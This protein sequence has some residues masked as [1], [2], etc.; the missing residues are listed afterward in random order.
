MNNPS[1]LDLGAR[2]SMPQPPALS[3]KSMLDHLGTFQADLKVVG[4]EGATE[5]PFAV[6][7]VLPGKTNPV[8]LGD[9]VVSGLR[10]SVR[11]VIDACVLVA[12]TVRRFEGDP[13]SLYEFLDV[14]AGGNVIPRKQARLGSKSSKLSKLRKI[15]DYAELLGRNEIIKHLEPGYTVNYHVTLLYDALPGDEDARVKRLVQILEAEGGLSREFLIEQ[16]RLA[17]QAARLQADPEADLW[18]ADTV[19]A[20][21][22]DFDLILLTPTRRD[23]Q[24]LGEDYAGEVP[25]CLRVHER[26]AVKAIAMSLPRL[27]IFR[28][29]EVGLLPSCGFENI[30]HVFLVREPVDA[31]VTGAQVIV[32]AERGVGGDHIPDFQWLPDGESLDD[33]YLA[34]RLVPDAKNKLH[35]F[36]SAPSDGWCSIVGEAN[37]GRSD[38]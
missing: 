7:G 27:R 31:D 12:G 2:A 14:L 5:P 37:W 11:A 25:W 23:L 22:R 18:N 24:R 21:D 19:S 20:R 26:V 8:A 38:A 15:G 29:S 16:T 35:A 33:G 32:I 6:P 13:G 10:S 28:R 36:A 4:L 17:E 34:S 3:R 1:S 30:S 9:L